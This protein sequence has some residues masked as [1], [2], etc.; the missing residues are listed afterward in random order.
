MEKYIVIYLNTELEIRKL[1]VYMLKHN[2]FNYHD[3]PAM[4]NVRIF[5]IV[6]HDYYLFKVNN[7]KKFLKYHN[8]LFTN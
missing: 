5:E 4:N 1:R 3:K 8:I 2:Y 6:S 7:L